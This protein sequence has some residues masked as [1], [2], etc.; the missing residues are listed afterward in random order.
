MMY[1]C[2]F[3]FVHYNAWEY[4][5]SDLLWAGIVTNLASAIEAE[6]GVM[7]SRIFRLL[8]VDVIQ[9]EASSNERT[10]L[11]NVRN[12]Q[13]NKDLKDILKEYG[14]VKRFKKRNENQKPVAK[15]EFSDYKEAA[16][17]YEAMTSNGAIVNKRHST[18]ES[19]PLFCQFCKHFMKHPKTT[20]GLPNLCWLL[21]FYLAF[22]C[23]LFIASQVAKAFDLDIYRVSL[24]TLR[25]FA[26]IQWEV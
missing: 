14:V 10:L 22:F 16:N 23:L 24:K 15:V 6:F 3:I 17:A 1:S 7:T 18:K 12:D 21:L 4:V 25:D 5:G 13:T 8:N 20:L 11:I 19:C 2:R 26:F 9:D